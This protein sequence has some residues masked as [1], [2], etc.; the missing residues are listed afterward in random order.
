MSV[1]VCI[2]GCFRVSVSVCVICLCVCVWRLWVCLRLLSVQCENA[3]VRVGV[4][5]FVSVIAWFCCVDVLVALDLYLFRN[6]PRKPSFRR[7]MHVRNVRLAD[8]APQ[9]PSFRDL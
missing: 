6:T 1:F 8:P 7:Q 5:V 2:S 9:D 3:G 4:S